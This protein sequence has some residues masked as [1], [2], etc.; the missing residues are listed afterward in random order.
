ME[1]DVHGKRQLKLHNHNETYEMNS[2]M[3]LIRFLPLPGVDWVGNVRIKCQETG[4]EADICYK[5]N[6]FLGRRKN[7]RAIAG[8]IYLSLTKETIYEINGHW[9]RFVFH[10]QLGLSYDRFDDMLLMISIA[11]L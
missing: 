3:L 2:P 6:S 5:A 10:L 8:K 11:E 4:I 1:T 7:Y 9:D